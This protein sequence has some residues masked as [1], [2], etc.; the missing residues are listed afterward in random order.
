MIV[1]I[2][3]MFPDTTGQ[4][5]YT[6]SSQRIRCITGVLQRRLTIGT[7]NQPDPPR[8]EVVDHRIG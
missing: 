3:G 7:L 8:T 5:W 2:V 4:Q 6:R 1:D